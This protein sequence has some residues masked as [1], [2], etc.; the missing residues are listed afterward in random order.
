MQRMTKIT[1]E[2]RE[3]AITILA[4]YNSLKLV[5]QGGERLS[6]ENNVAAHETFVA[7]TGHQIDLE[8]WRKIAQSIRMKEAGKDFASSSTVQKLEPVQFLCAECPKTF[9]L[10]SILKKH[11]RRDHKKDDETVDKYKLKTCDKC[12]LQLSGMYSLNHHMKTKHGSYA[13]REYKCNFPGCNMAFF[14]ASNLKLHKPKHGERNFVCDHCGESFWQSGTLEN[15]L[16][17]K[18]KA[19]PELKLKCKYCDEIFLNYTERMLHT[20]LEHFPERHKCNICQKTFGTNFLLTKHGKSAHSDRTFIECQECG[21]QLANEQG[22]KSHMRLHKGE[23]VSCSYCPWKSHI[24]SK[25]YKHM[26]LQH[27]EDWER[28]KEINKDIIKCPDCEKFVVS[29]AALTYHRG[30]VHG[31]KLKTCA[32]KI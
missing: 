10:R 30:K 2:M 13:E 28:E 29:K 27:K 14:A 9:P 24:P 7:K 23:L 16:R 6:H 21:K 22:L 3:I 31:Q 20:N 5:Q 18:H 32:I 8:Q 11:I 25:L 4:K 26:R 12:G 1:K 17:N 19:L 15:H